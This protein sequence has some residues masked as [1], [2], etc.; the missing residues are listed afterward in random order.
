MLWFLPTHTGFG[1]CYK[2]DASGLPLIDTFNDSD[3]VNDAGLD[4]SEVAYDADTKTYDPSL[5]E[6]IPE[7]GPLDPRLDYTV[8]RRTI[9]FNGWGANPGKVWVRATFA[10]ISGPYLAKKNF[11]QAGEDENRG[12]GAWG[13]QRPGI[14][15]NIMRFADVLLMAA[16]A[17]VEKPSPD[18]GLALDYV[19]RVRNRAKNMTYVAARG[20]G[21]EIIPDTPAANYVIE[22]YASF[23]D[24][25]SARDAV[26]FE[27]RLELA[28]EGHRLFDLRRWGI[29]EQTMNEYAANEARAI[30]NF[31]DKFRVYEPKHDLLP[32]PLNAI[33]LSGGI[34]SQNPGF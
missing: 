16:E 22:P 25:N 30:P 12:T 15:Y 6:F 18:L 5:D 32:I 4:T 23:A 10:D 29:A 34:L 17:A 1:K 7:Q 33:D 26:R 14:N 21:D 28:M 19:N 24:V 11:Y 8:G 13:E 2:T 20:A 3:I 9:D 31:G 27:R